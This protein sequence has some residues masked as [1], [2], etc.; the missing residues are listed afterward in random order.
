MSTADTADTRYA[1]GAGAPDSVGA[2]SS[3]L[4]GGIDCHARTHHAVALDDRRRRL[5][6]RA[7]AATRAGYRDVLAWLG[8]FGP[9]VAVGVES[10]GAYGP[11]G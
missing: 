10:T 4:I 11:A 9:L 1:G 2:G 7:G 6:D 8:Q 5:G 3:G